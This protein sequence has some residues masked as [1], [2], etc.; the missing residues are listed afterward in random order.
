MKLK[1]KGCGQSAHK[2]LCNE[3]SQ[4]DTHWK[5]TYFC[6]SVNLRSPIYLRWRGFILSV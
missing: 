4:P 2:R 5:P 3:Y 1:I 6:A